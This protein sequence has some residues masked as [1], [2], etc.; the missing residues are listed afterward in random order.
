MILVSKYAIISLA[1]FIFFVSIANT[2]ELVIRRR[3]MA[4][5]RSGRLVDYHD[6]DL[7]NVK[8]FE[9]FYMRPD[10]DNF[11]YNLTSGGD[12][13]MYTVIQ[14]GTMESR[15]VTSGWLLDETGNVST[16]D[17]KG[18]RVVM[19]SVCDGYRSNGD[20]YSKGCELWELPKC[21]NKNQVFDQR[22][23]DFRD[24]RGRSVM[25]TID[26]NGSLILSDCRDT[27]WRWSDCECAGYSNYMGQD[28][29][30]SYW[31]GGDLEWVQDNSGADDKIYV[32][33]SPP[34]GTLLYAHHN[35]IIL[36]E[37]T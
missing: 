30:C 17:D 7:G 16:I 5:W 3:G 33:Q 22:S 35:I 28:Y 29:G 37:L 24:V 21:R 14:G 4:Y 2:G 13:F 36:N 34:K 25:P 20:G 18:L 12:Y 6:D 26:G 32:L 8:N 31:I 1:I 19:A 15:K 11:N 27:C 23:G 9:N 10:R